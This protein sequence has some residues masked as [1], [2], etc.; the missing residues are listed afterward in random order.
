MTTPLSCITGGHCRLAAAA[1]ACDVSE[2]FLD[3]VN[4]ETLNSLGMHG[5]LRAINYFE[6]DTTAE[7]VQQGPRPPTMGSAWSPYLT[8][9]ITCQYRCVCVCVLPS[10]SNIVGDECIDQRQS[11]IRERHVRACARTIKKLTRRD[12]WNSEVRRGSADVKLLRGVRTLF[13]KQGMFESRSS[14]RIYH[15]SS[16]FSLD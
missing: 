1:L 9:V 14:C 4:T 15:P 6:L 5:I 2:G 3:L 13:A 16:S 11:T 10:T 7:S 12:I 8:P